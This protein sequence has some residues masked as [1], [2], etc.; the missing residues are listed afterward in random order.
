MN[1]AAWAE[2]KGV[3]RVSAYRWF[4][5][6]L[7]SVPARRVGRL[8]LV[9]DSI[10]LAGPRARTAVYGGCLRPIRKQ[11]SIGRWRG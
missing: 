11:I 10:G 9:G 5:S 1:L 4:L 2:R 3:A 7:L 6:G 8:V